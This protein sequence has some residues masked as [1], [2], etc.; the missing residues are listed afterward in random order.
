MQKK[1]KYLH[2]KKSE[3]YLH[4]TIF[5]GEKIR[6]KINEAKT[7][8]ICLT[9]AKNSLIISF[10]N[11]PNRGTITGSET[12]KMLGFVF[13][14]K[15]T[16]EAHANYLKKF[17]AERQFAPILTKKNCASYMQVT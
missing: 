6:M 12:L 16:A 14:R 15:P 2:A 5:N 13:G 9:V 8:M 7:Q 4:L 3:D 17:Y 10:I 1:V 11:L